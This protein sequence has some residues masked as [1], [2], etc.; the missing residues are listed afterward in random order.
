LVLYQFIATFVAMI[1]YTLRNASVNA[2]NVAHAHVV[3][4][5]EGML[6]PLRLLLLQALHATAV[7]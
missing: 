1:M 2:S 3:F 7:A 6:H 5:D 4:T